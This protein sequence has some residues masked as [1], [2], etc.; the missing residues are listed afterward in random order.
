MYKNG[1][2]NKVTQIPGLKVLDTAKFSAVK[3]VSCTPTGKC[4]AGG[5]YSSTSPQVGRPAFVADE[6]NGIWGQV[7]TVQVPS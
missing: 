4:A 3:S 7:Q 6:M 2:W 5:G 1:R